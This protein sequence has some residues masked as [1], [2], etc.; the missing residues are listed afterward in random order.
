MLEPLG[1]FGTPP[2]L[3]VA[4]SGGA[5]SLALAT[6][7]GAWARKRGG[8]IQAFIVDHRLRLE[9]GREA[10]L[11]AATLRRLAIPARIL[12]VDGIAPGPGL[13]ARARA[14]RFAAL[15]GACREAGILDLML[16]H[17]AA[18]QAETVIMRN[19]RSSGVAGLAGMA[20]INESAFVRL[21]R[22]LLGV[23]PGRLRATLCAQSLDWAEDPTN[24]DG[25]F[26]R[27][28]LRTAR[29]DS[30]GTG[31]ATKALVEASA[32]DALARRAGELAT[33]TWLVRA[34]TI[35][36]EGFALLPKGPWPSAALAVLLRMVTGSHHMPPAEAVAAIAAAPAASIGNGVC[37]AGARLRPAGRLG[38]A[39]GADFLICREAAAMGA[40]VPADPG[41]RWDG[42]FRRPS[43]LPAIPHERIGPLGAAAR[44]F[45]G[46]SDL[47]ALVLETLPAYLSSTGDVVAVPAL[48]WP[49]FPYQI[50]R[51]VVFG[52]PWPAA[53]AGFGA[54]FGSG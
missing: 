41:A 30:A 38:E 45:R 48:D 17:H 11:A 2:S 32:A 1:P 33:A 15:E 51:S 42:R 16:G 49:D 47:P 21:L 10:E 27:A 4:V 53:G 25:K 3:A 14:A 22:P 37:L 23:P 13:P 12:A 36:P 39:A 24:V 5:D 18:D 8:T 43:H 29:G 31:P 34:A 26:T 44:R 52:P 40:P 7:A 35:R 20:A 54:G 6:L 19:L 9:S 28:R 50:E 46:I